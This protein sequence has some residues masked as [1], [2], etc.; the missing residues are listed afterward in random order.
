MAI[1]AAPSADYAT[2][3]K[4]TFLIKNAQDLFL[5]TYVP[6]MKPAVSPT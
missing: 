1:S 5:K 3:V 6:P 4:S 2:I